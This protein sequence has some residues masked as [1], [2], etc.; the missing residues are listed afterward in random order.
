MKVVKALRFKIIN[1]NTRKKSKLNHTVRQFRR[2][3]N[4]Y[5]HEIGKA[6]QKISNK[7]LPS[8]YSK[9]K[10]VFDL[11][12]ALLQQA[13]R[14]A[15]EQYKSCKNN[16]NN[17]TFPHFDGFVPVRYDKRTMTVR[18]SEGHFSLWVSLSTTDGRVRVPIEG[19]DKLYNYWK[20][21]EFDFEDARLTL[22]G[23]K[24][25]LTVHVETETKIPKEEEFEHFVG[26]DSGVN[27][28]AV[29]VVQDRKGNIL[30]GGY[31]GAKRKCYNQ[32]RREYARKK[33]WVK[34]KREKGKE[35]RFM[36]DVNHKVSR[37]IVDIAKEYPNSCI[38]MEKLNDIRQ[39][40]RGTK[41]QNRRLHNWNFRQLQEFL[42]YKAHLS[43]VAYRKVP[44]Y[45]TSQVCRHCGERALKRSFQN[46]V[47]AVCKSCKKEANADFTAAV[48]IVRRL[49]SYIVSGS[50]PRE[51]GP[52]Q[53]SVEDKGD[54]AAAGKYQLVSQLSPSSP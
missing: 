14:F 46:A 24:F 31:V 43:G 10:E 47:I 11:P 49:W 12:T 26:V 33:L 19:G 50:G 22:K 42:E 35:K 51:S 23:S 53:G 38:V 15:I 45:L 39:R 6:P 18:K 44:A 9:A 48:N 34:L 30:D 13:G 17:G 1:P 52:N 36:R 32:K 28:L 21:K 54:T 29:I 20:N 37:A 40:I 16:E 41:K 3:V 8:I 5:L 4:F 7:N 27:N 25:Y 2:A